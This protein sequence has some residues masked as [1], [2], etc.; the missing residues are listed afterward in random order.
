MTHREQLFVVNLDQGDGIYLDGRQIMDRASLSLGSVIQLG[1][2]EFEVIEL[3]RAQSMIGISFKNLKV[4]NEGGVF[5]V[6]V[7]NV[8]I[9]RNEK[10]AHIKFPV[11]SR[12]LSREHARFDLENNGI[13]ITDLNSTNGTFVNVTRVTEPV[14]LKDGDLIKLGDITLEIIDVGAV[15]LTKI[16]TV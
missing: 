16:E 8:V 3:T 11:S 1:S 5:T 2:N 13:Y 12:K 10:T 9:G 14:L 15:P 6:R 4:S 7:P